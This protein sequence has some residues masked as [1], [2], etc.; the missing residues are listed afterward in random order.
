MNFVY[1]NVLDICRGGQQVGN[2][3][4]CQN[5]Q[6]AGWWIHHPLG[7]FLHLCSSYCN[8][9]MAFQSLLMVRNHETSEALAAFVDS[10][11]WRVEMECRKGTEEREEEK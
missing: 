10:S 4:T 1:M 7:L 5:L 6:S 9:I 11:S 2:Q 8:G 3:P